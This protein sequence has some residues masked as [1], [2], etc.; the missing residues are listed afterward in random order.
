MQADSGYIEFPG[1]LIQRKQRLLAVPF[2]L[3]R[4]ENIKIINKCFTPVAPLAHVEPDISGLGIGLRLYYGI[5]IS[6]F[7]VEPLG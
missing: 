5:E 6:P 7:R 1:F 2:S 3:K 4:F